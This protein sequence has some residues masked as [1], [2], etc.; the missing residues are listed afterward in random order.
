MESE[1]D[2][3]AEMVAEVVLEFGGA[4]MRREAAQ[5]AIERVVERV[6]RFNGNKV[7]FYLEAY[8][9][10]MEAEVVDATL[11]MEFFCRVVAVWMHAEVK[12]LREAHSSWEAFEEALRQ[13]YGEPPKGWNRRDFDQWISATN[14]HRGAMKAFKEFKR[15]F[16]RLPEREQRLLGADK[17]LLFVRPIERVEWEAMGIELEDDD[18]TNGLTEDWS[19]VERVCRRLDKERSTKSKRK[20]TCDGAPSQ[21]EV[22]GQ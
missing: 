3:S 18:G 12:A 22:G 6:S 20:M 11:R 8:N 21:Q 10:E 16:A 5:R 1:D 15:H 4:V 14:T 7:P 13:A 19:E 17:V 9:A 2:D